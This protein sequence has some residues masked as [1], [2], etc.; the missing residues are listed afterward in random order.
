MSGGRRTPPLSEGYRLVTRIFS[1]TIIGFGLAMVIVTLARG[2]GPAST[3][4][5]FGLLFCAI[6][7]AR[8]YLATRG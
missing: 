4:F 1:V 3:G 8:L 2:G 6:G 5:L 7:A